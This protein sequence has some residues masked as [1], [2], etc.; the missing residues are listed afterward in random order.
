MEE[1]PHQREA[2]EVYYRL[3]PQRSY[4][5]MAKETGYSRGSIQNW[6]RAFNW[7]ERLEERIE[8]EGEAAENT[9]ITRKL[10]DLAQSTDDPADLAHEVDSLISKLNITLDACFKEGEDGA[11]VPRFSVQDASEFAGIV[12]AQ[13]D[14]LELRMKLEKLDERQTNNK[15]RAQNV[16][17]I[18]NFMGQMSSEERMAFITGGNYDRQVYEGDGGVPVYVDGPADVGEEDGDRPLPE[19]QDDT[20]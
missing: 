1:K 20:D 13:K 18:N 2:F 17:Q 11:L 3:G 8:K 14:L 19:G 6:A 10:T 15:E 12:K 7:K 4:N 5:R 16:T 9:L